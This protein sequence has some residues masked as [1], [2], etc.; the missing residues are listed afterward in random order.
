MQ[1]ISNFDSEG[2]GD[3]AK[4]ITVMTVPKKE[5][6]IYHTIVCNHVI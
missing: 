4:G 3:S 5:I 1:L 6:P 2:D